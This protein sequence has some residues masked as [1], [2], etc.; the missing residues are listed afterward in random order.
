MKKTNLIVLCV[1]FAVLIGLVFVKKNMKARPPATEEMVDLIAAPVNLEDFSEIVLRLGQEGA[2][3]NASTVQRVELARE[4]GQWIVKTQYGVRAN[5]KAIAP[6]LEKLDAL[7]GELR[8]QRKEVLTDYG[9]EDDQGVH[10]EL[11]RE[12]AQNIHIV[13]GTKKAG[14]QNNFVRLAGTNDVYVVGENLLGAL[15]V[16]EEEGAQKLDTDKWGDKRITNLV[17]DNVVGVAI[18]QAVNGS[19]QTV[20]D[21]RKNTVDDKKQWQSV[22]P[23]AF[24]LSASKI[25]SLLESFNNTYARDIVAPDNPSV[26]DAPDWIGTFT[27]E[28]GNE[29][30][31]V[32]GAKDESGENYY[33]KID[34]AGYFYRIPVSTF[35]GR[36]KQQGDIFASNP[37]NVEEGSVDGI[38][39]NDVSNKKKFDAVKIASAQVTP[40]PTG[41]D[42]AQPESAPE[43]VWQT[44]AG[45]N[46][47]TDKVQDVIA[48]IKDMN[49]EAVFGPAVSPK[50]T[51][52]ISI[53]KADGKKD[54]TLSEETKLSNGKECHFLKLN[55]EFQNYCVSKDQV[56]AL[57]NVLP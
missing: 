26:F 37:L 15:G 34:G 31:L 56:T 6:V 27:F 36:E 14:Y 40:E 39:V 47:E 2:E 35:E 52:A 17:V 8:S 13:V 16:R 12:G 41:D 33:A 44:P 18:A 51:L 19:S 10:V 57:K 4:N 45:A 53:I 23:Y 20:M 11:Y 25:K 43:V 7:Q 55:G 1:I 28:D 3:E 49:V 46:V 29:V 21:I 22:Y 54:Y 50:E 48:K 30:K 24:G 32:R 42:A 5:E 9:I 38:V